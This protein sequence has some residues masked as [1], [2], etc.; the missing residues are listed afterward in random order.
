[1]PKKKSV[2]WKYFDRKGDLAVCKVKGCGC[3]LGVKSTLSMFYHLK[4]KHKID[5]ID[6]SSQNFEVEEPSQLS[7]KRSREPPT[8]LEVIQIFECEYPL[9]S[10]NSRNIAH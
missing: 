3:K 4:N 10:H 5:E 2:D 7:N 1:M 8:F 9:L 6:S